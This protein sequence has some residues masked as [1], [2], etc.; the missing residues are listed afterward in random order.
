[1]RLASADHFAGFAAE[2]ALK[3][4]ILDYLGGHL[5]KSSRPTH[6]GLTG[7]PS[8]GH[9]NEIWG[10]LASTAHG[11][12]ANQFSAFLGGPNPFDNWNVGERYS[13]GTHLDEQ[14]V[15]DHLDAANQAISMHEQ[16][17]INGALS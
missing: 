4:I 14:H 11:R 3:A 12:T 15:D 1:M 13:D 7:K 6:S 2:C 9:A 8:F 17:K 5:D 16:A 10:Q